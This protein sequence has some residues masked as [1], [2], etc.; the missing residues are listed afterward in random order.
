[1]LLGGA[2]LALGV[3]LG[4]PYLVLALIGTALLYDAGGKNIAVVGNLLMGLCRSGNFLLGAAA[5]LGT[6]KALNHGVLVLGA[7]ILGCYIFC[8]T[9]SSKLEEEEFDFR[10]L[11]VRAL[12]LF[13][14]PVLFV[15]LAPRQPMVWVNSSL[16]LILLADALRASS[17]AAASPHHGVEIFVRKALAGIFLVDAGILLAFLPAKTPLSRVAA[18]VL[19]LYL[20]AAIGWVWKHRWIQAGSSGS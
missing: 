5:S 11:C 13:V 6:W 12:P 4:I 18:L 14:L 2:S 1:M 8:V 15:L 10:R 20:L 7:A 19:G 9:A 3:L 17:L 16:L